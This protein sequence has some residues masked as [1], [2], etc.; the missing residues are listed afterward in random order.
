MTATIRMK[1][2]MRM[3]FRIP[4]RDYEHTGFRSRVNQ[5]TRH[6]DEYGC[7]MKPNAKKESGAE[8]LKQSTRFTC[9]AREEA[10]YAQIV[11]HECWCM[12]YR[13]VAV[14][15]HSCTTVISGCLIQA[16]E[17]R[18][19]SLIPL[20]AS[21]SLTACNSCNAC[22]IPAPPAFAPC[23]PNGTAPQRPPPS[24]TRHALVWYTL[25]EEKGV[26]FYCS[27]THSL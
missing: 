8:C 9:C 16:V 20:V 7:R 17:E 14:R 4:V 24:C 25:C 19:A 11:V 10:R 12:C 18:S 23:F 6:W 27:S 2:T 21:L 26:N 1:V 15:S 3:R 5:F 13:S 22:L